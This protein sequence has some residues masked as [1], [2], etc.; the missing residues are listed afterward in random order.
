MGSQPVMGFALL[1]IQ[2]LQGPETTI[3]EAAVEEVLRDVNNH[4]QVSEIAPDAET[5]WLVSRVLLSIIETYQVA[6]KAFEVREFQVHL[7][8]W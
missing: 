4:F 5:F 7:F 2:N 6:T 3:P 1:V 8:K